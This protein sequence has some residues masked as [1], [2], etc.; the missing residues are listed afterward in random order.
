MRMLWIRQLGYSFGRFAFSGLGFNLISVM[1]LL[2]TNFLLLHWFSLLCLQLRPKAARSEPDPVMFVLKRVGV[3]EVCYQQNHNWNSSWI[4]VQKRQTSRKNTLIGVWFWASDD[5]EVA[6]PLH[7][8]TEFRLFRTSEYR[9][10][11]QNLELFWVFLPWGLCIDCYYAQYLN[12]LWNKLLSLL[13]IFNV[14][15]VCGSR[16][17]SFESAR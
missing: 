12:C 13:V 2:V 6:R 4:Q 11:I 8:Y 7:F 10:K 17:L 16:N 3:E 1:I 5:S 9:N 14:F 15:V